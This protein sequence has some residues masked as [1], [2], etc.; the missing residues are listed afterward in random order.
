MASCPISMPPIGPGV[1]SVSVRSVIIARRVVSR[2]VVG[3]AIEYRQRNRDRQA[4]EDSSLR[5]SLC[6][7]HDA[8]H[9]SSNQ[10]KFS[11]LDDL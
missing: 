1:E 5:W 7:H 4:D 6:Q 3:W 10:E 9:E 8:D 2:R 11:H